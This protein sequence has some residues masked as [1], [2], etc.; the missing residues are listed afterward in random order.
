VAYYLGP[1]TQSLRLLMAAYAAANGLD[2]DTFSRQFE[3]ELKP[4]PPLQTRR[5]AM[6]GRGP[7]REP[8]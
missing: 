2:P 3:A 6:V 4:E 1:Y 8:A 7:G 5:G